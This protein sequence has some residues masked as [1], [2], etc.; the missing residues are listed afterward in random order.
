MRVTW[1]ASYY[2]DNSDNCELWAPG[3]PLF[4]DRQSL[5]ASLGCV[6]VDKRQFTQLISN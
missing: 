4:P 6:A 3:S 1:K 2:E 5:E